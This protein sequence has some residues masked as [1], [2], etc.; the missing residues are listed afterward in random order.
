[1]GQREAD[2]RVFR[3][4]AGGISG[5]FTK[6]PDLAAFPS[7]WTLFRCPW[8]SCLIGMLFLRRLYQSKYELMVQGSW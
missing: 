8:Y 2:G 1:M 5:H 6:S 4:L 7:A 3:A